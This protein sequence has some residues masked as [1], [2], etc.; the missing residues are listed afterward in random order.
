MSPIPLPPLLTPSG[1]FDTF[2]IGG[3]SSAPLPV[4]DYDI[5]NKL[6]VD[7]TLGTGFVRAPASSVTNTIH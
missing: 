1:N 6:Y 7:T 3:R 4:D 2:Q 5:V